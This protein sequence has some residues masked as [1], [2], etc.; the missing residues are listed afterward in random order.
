MQKMPVGKESISISFF[1]RSQSIF[2]S[3]PAPAKLKFR[4][5][6]PVIIRT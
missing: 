2:I 4:C 5:S 1:L 6:F 3:F